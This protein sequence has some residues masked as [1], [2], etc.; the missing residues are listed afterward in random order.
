MDG[1]SFPRGVRHGTAFEVIRRV[2]ARRRG[3]LD[4]GERRALAADA[5]RHR[6]AA[7][8]VTAG[9]K[10]HDDHIEMS[11]L[12]ASAIV[13]YGADRDGG[14]MLWRR[15]VWPMLRTVPNNTGASLQQAFGSLTCRRWSIDG[16]PVDERFDSAT[17]DGLLT[18]RTRGARKCS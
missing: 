1:L 7:G 4:R 18:I 16:K 2:A 12:R 15:V 14:L 13:Q 8:E 6:V 10:P 5:R 3:A 9:P 17:I 11:G